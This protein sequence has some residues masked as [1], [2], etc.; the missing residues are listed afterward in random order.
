V[1][2]A[3]LNVNESTVSAPDQGVAVHR[4][5]GLPIEGFRFQKDRAASGSTSRQVTK[6]PS[7]SQ[8]I[9]GGIDIFQGA[10]ESDAI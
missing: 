10:S 2:E 9:S 7:T 3:E 1:V 6:A 8:S 4:A 5:R